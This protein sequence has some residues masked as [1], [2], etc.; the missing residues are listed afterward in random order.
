MTQGDAPAPDSAPDPSPDSAH[1]DAPLVVPPGV[2]LR[3]WDWLLPPLL[4]AILVVILAW[5][6]PVPLLKPYLIT[7]ASI[8]VTVLFAQWVFGFRAYT[9]W[10]DVDVRWLRRSQSAGIAALGLFLLPYFFGMMSACLFAVSAYRF[11]DD[12]AP[13]IERVRSG[14]SPRAWI[15]LKVIAVIVGVVALLGRPLASAFGFGIPALILAFAAA[16]AFGFALRAQPRDH[17][18]LPP[19]VRRRL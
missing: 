17:A 2:P 18:P 6:P 4:V 9:R 14:L 12:P 3:V 15:R 19:R 5:F 11:A 10:E 1:N 8:L 16:L 7:T 13:G